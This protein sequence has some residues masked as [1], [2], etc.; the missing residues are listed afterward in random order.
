[1]P[2]MVEPDNDIDF[3]EKDCEACD[4]TGSC[5]LCSGNNEDCEECDGTGDCQECDGSG[6]ES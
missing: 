1:M 5:P 3:D 6:T 4:G 2:K